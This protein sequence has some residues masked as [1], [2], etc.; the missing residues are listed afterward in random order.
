MVLATLPRPP[1]TKPRLQEGHP[2]P[3]CFRS[4]K[5]P[6]RPQCPTGPS[7]P[8]VSSQEVFGT[9][10]LPCCEELQLL[11]GLPGSCAERLEKLSSS[12]R[13]E[14][15]VSGHGVSVSVP[16]GTLPG[17]RREVGGTIILSNQAPPPGD[18]KST[19]CESFFVPFQPHPVG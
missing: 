3:T 14:G 16:G 11:G 7:S 10:L 19:D 4:L 13:S 18:R 8:A 17:S 9:A 12:A 2:V 1:L 5:A 15:S 6:S